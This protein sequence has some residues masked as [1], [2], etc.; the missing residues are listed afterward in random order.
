MRMRRVECKPPFNWCSKS[1]HGLAKGTA[2]FATDP[3]QEDSTRV[4]LVGNQW[5][6]V[7]HENILAFVFGEKRPLVG[8]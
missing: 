6:P 4:M 7:D 3:R 1:G 5:I 2:Q 8:G